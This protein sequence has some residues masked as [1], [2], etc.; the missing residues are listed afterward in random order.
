MA[1]AMVTHGGH[2]RR[3]CHTR[4]RRRDEKHGAFAA[5]AAPLKVIW[6]YGDMATAA[7]CAPFD[8]AWQSEEIDRTDETAGSTGTQRSPAESEVL[9]VP[10]QRIVQRGLCVCVVCRRL[11]S[12]GVCVA[13]ARRRGR[14]GGLPLAHK[15]LSKTLQLPLKMRVCL[16]RCAYG[17]TASSGLQGRASGA[18]VQRH[19]HPRPRGGSWRAVCT[20]GHGGLS[21][22]CQCGK[23][24]AFFA[25]KHFLAPKNKTGFC[26]AGFCAA[27][28]AF[29]ELIFIPALSK[30]GNSRHGVGVRLGGGLGFVSL[31]EAEQKP[32]LLLYEGGAGVSNRRR[33]R[34]VQ[35]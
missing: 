34:R 28:A 35:A 5:S 24:W 22:V 1:I 4:R 11:G 13:E 16:M 17:L 31:I 27:R 19:G 7:M 33:E 6:R 30:K 26:A 18:K 9:Q 15:V 29:W 14:G 20:C 10:P 8:K 3:G 23:K 21:F 25:I 2:T 12:F 32:R